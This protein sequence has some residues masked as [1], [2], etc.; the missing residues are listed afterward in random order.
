MIGRLCLSSRDNYIVKGKSVKKCH[1]ISDRLEDKLIT[2]SKEYMSNDIY[3]YTDIEG[4]NNIIKRNLGIIGNKDDDKNIYYHL[5]TIDWMS[6]KKYYELG[7][8]LN[9]DY[10]CKKNRYKYSDEVITID[11]KFSIDLDDG[12]TI[13]EDNNKYIID[14]HIADPTSYF[15]F[16]NPITHEIIKE[17]KKR[18]CTCYI[19]FENKINHL[20]PMNIIKM[21]TLVRDGLNKRAITFRTILNK[22]DNTYNVEVLYTTIENIKNYT[23]EDYDTQ[24]LQVD[25][26]IKERYITICKKLLKIMDCKIN[27][28][29][30][31][32]C[33]KFIEVLMI[34]VNYIAGNK[35]NNLLIRTQ[36][37]P[38]KSENNLE[39]I[40]DII[41]TL[42]N[43]S[44]NYKFK[45]ENENNFHYSLNVVNYSH[46]SS[47]MRR[48]IDMYNHFIIHNYSIDDYLTIIINEDNITNICNIIKNQKRISNAY[49]LIK[50]LEKDNEF[51]AYIIDIKDIS[52]KLV[53]LGLY[54]EKLNIKKI[55]LTK[56]PIK[57]D[58]NI[59]LFD[60]FNVKLNYNSALFKNHIYPFSITI[61]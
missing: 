28:D 16:K 15:D 40:P 22:D 14:I 30:N 53:L 8:R 12:F 4:D 37:K 23:Y 17:L 1:I 57:T 25:N 19:P 33:H 13:F 26:N 2:T 24:V 61:L 56:L 52:N 35:Y 42:L 49:E 39:H 43:F 45:N 58:N 9:L 60:T 38:E 11:P 54:N 46:I 41:K 32:L 59:K 55:L 3:I 48:F 47:P 36:E 50:I 29:I 5:Y 21:V 27:F 51:K 31:D 20:L 6:K 44:A 34:W 18:L 7:L 10:D